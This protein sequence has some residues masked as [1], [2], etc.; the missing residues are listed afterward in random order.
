[1]FTL[2]AR[3]IK[4]WDVP[5]GKLRR[6][7]ET[8]DAVWSLAFSPSGD[9]LAAAGWENGLLVW[10]LTREL[11]PQKVEGHSL[12]T[13][14]V[15]FSPDGRT[16][17]STGSD[18]TIRLWENRTWQTRGILRGHGNE[19][20][21]AA[22]SPDG[23]WLVSGSKDETIAI[24]R[25]DATA[26]TQELAGSAGRRPALSP[27]G[28]WLVGSAS[29]HTSPPVLWD[30]RERKPVA[31]IPA[32][33]VVCFSRDGRQ[34]ICLNAS[35]GT[36][37]RW[38]V[39]ERRFGKSVPLAGAAAGLDLE[40]W[41][42]A[43]DLEAFFGVHRDG[44]IS[45]WSLSTGE[46]LGQVQGPAPPLRSVALAP[47][48]RRLAVSVE[49]ENL[50]RLFD[51]TTGQER[52]LAGH[53]DF[54]SGLA[55]SPDGATLASG[56]VDATIKLWEVAGARE[57]ATLTGHMQEATDLVYSPDG[58]T[59]VSLEQKQGMKWWHLGTRR[60][61]ASL[62]F[63]VIAQSARFSLDGS[64]LVV[65]SRDGLLRLYEAPPLS[66]CDQARP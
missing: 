54:V 38:E 44:S 10:D 56:S 45:V 31:S 49:R 43:P 41:G 59:L 30:L 23:A 20:W 13:W 50:I 2:P 5:S 18:Q 65:A 19:V 22:F 15:T 29:D 32:E 61:M 11:P 9:Q 26:R 37:N 33:Q 16:L 51:V 57:T 40:T 52:Q 28:R 14:W 36:L 46:S 24:W 6:S 55:F 60:E 7:L 64:V 48:G 47:G 25:T 42:H 12:N 35:K 27:D 3:G 1:M 53:R 21:C 34:V 63:P 4:L 66:E 62:A 39:E 8:G 58:R 17:A